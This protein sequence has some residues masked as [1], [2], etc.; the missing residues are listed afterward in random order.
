MAFSY[1]GP[2]VLLFAQADGAESVAKVTTTL[3]ETLPGLFELSFPHGLTAAVNAVHV[4]VTLPSGSTLAGPVR[5][6]AASMLTFRADDRA[7]AL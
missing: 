1:V 7:A 4:S 2:A 3:G 6:L 5:Y